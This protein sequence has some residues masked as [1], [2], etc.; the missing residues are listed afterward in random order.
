MQYLEVAAAL[1]SMACLGRPQW[2]GRQRSHRGGGTDGGVVTLIQCCS[3]DQKSGKQHLNV[4][5]R[6]NTMQRER[7]RSERSEKKKKKRKDM[8]LI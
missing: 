8:R 1:R 3:L 4:P 6:E 7:A 2:G 5:G